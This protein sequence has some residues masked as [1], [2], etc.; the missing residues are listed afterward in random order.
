MT[1]IENPQTG[2][3]ESVNHAWNTTPVQVWVDVDSGIA[4]L[5]RALNGIDGL[6]THASCQGHL[7]SQF[8]TRAYVYISWLTIAAWEEITKILDGLGGQQGD[9][10]FKDF[11]HDTHSATLLVHQSRLDELTAVLEGWW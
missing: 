11:S 6:R 10:E 5:V 1:R 7:L 2:D 4:P 3:D 8:D 9:F